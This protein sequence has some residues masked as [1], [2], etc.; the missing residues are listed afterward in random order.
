[1]EPTA[2]RVRELKESLEEGGTI[3]TNRL[4]PTTRRVR[5]LHTKA[6]L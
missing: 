6:G 5:E 4:E 2:K 3:D 1:M